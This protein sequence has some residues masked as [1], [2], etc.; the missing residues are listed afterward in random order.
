MCFSNI[1]SML[2]ER[3]VLC[4]CV[5]VR[6]VCRVQPQSPKKVTQSVSTPAGL[7]QAVPVSQA[8]SPATLATTPTPSHIVSV[9][10]HMEPPEAN[11]TIPRVCSLQLLCSCVFCMI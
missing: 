9:D 3:M 10:C 8:T 7:H 1:T 6:C 4:T 5:C 11:L 2:A